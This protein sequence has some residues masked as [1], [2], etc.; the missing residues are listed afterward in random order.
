MTIAADDFSP[1]YQ[2]DTAAEFRPQFLHK[3]GSAMDLTG[4]TITMIMQDSEGNVKAGAGTW[5]ID[6]TLTA[7]THFDFDAADVDTAGNW[8]LFIAIAINGKTVHADT[9]QLQI[10]PVPTP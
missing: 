2:H 9:K 6:N 8:T 5:T 7:Q 3:D 10:L 4:A 1:I